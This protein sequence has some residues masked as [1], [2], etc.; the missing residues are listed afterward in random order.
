MSS[1]IR[2]AAGACVLFAAF[3]AAGWLWTEPDAGSLPLLG[4]YAVL[5]I[6]TFFSIRA[7]ASITPRNT[8]QTLFD[9]A[10][11]CTYAALAFSFSSTILFLAISAL[12]FMLS[13]AKYT[14]LNR[15][16]SYPELLR[17]KITL[18]ALAALLSGVMLAVA[19]TGYPDAAT[20]AL[21]VSFALPSIFLQIIPV[22]RL[23]S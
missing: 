19:F 13:I 4:Y 2:K 14:H 23:D 6:N 7:L 3:G 5:V 1:S 10:L 15:L 12:L 22:Y 17:R 11:V 8:P 20:W 9:A 21:F 16:V 18:N